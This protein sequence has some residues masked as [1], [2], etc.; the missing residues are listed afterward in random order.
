M[1][2]SWPAGFIQGIKIP[3][4]IQGI[5]GVPKQ[6]GSIRQIVINGAKHRVVEDVE[7]LR[8]KLKVYM[9]VYGNTPSNGRIKL[10]EAES[11]RVVSWEIS[12]NADRCTLE[13]VIVNNPSTWI[14]VAVQIKRLSGNKIRL[15][16][17]Y[18]TCIGIYYLASDYGHRLGRLR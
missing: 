17:L 11:I 12:L 7:C 3:H 2:R 10:Y 5:I 1:E 16:I 4:G 15:I 13:S 14:L 18:G 9:I 8:A 6:S